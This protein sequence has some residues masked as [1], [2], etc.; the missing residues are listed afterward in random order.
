MDMEDGCGF[1]LFPHSDFA[2]SSLFDLYAAIA[3]LDEVVNVTKDKR[4][5]RATR[6]GI[7]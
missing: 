6:F 5:D 3:A 1:I 7:V 4:V 2:P